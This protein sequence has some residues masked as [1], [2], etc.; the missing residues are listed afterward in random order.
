MPYE[1]ID[2]LV[3]KAHN[4][5]RQTVT[6]D[7]D[8]TPPGEA[9]SPGRRHPKGRQDASATPCLRTRTRNRLPSNSASAVPSESASTL[10]RGHGQVYGAVSSS[11]RSSNSGPLC[12]MRL[13]IA[14]EIPNLPSTLWMVVAPTVWD[15][16]ILPST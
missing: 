11:P 5:M 1:D 15:T 12:R 2:D 7:P 14:C 9:L 13:P 4:A 6:D 8:R 10:T 16:P 3:G